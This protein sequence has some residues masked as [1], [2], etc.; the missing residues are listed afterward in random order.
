MTSQTITSTKAASS[1]TEIKKVSTNET[2]FSF[3]FASDP[4][5]M[6]P[7]DLQWQVALGKEISKAV[8]DGVDLRGADFSNRDMRRLN[9]TGLDLRGADFSGSALDHSQL[10]F[11]NLSNANL[12]GVHMVRGSLA[13]ANLLGACLAG[14]H[15][16]MTDLTGVVAWSGERASELPMSTAKRSDK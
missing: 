5:S 16:S 12:R 13:H 8:Q 4:E 3:S 14:A 10:A 2:L 9:L 1:I 11:A 6:S 15:F 7:R